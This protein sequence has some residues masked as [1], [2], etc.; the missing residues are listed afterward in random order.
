VTNWQNKIGSEEKLHVISWLKKGELIL[1]ICRNVRLAHSSIHTICD[2]A[3]RIKES[4]K[5]GT[6][7]FVCVARLPQSNQ[8]EPYQ[9][10]VDMNLLHFYCIR[11]K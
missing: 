5:S 7:V 6:K 1:D 9:K 2:N 4:A 3:N 8:N 10:T 11:N